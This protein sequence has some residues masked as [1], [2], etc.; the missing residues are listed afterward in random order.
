MPTPPPSRDPSLLET[1]LLVVAEMLERST[2]E[3]EGLLAQIR[4]G[5]TGEARAEACQEHQQE[6][7]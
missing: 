6:E 1:R 5:G 4:A 2:R 3:V 7:P